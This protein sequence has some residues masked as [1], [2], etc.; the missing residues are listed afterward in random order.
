MAEVYFPLMLPAWGPLVMAWE[1]VFILLGPRLLEPLPSGCS[2]HF[3][4]KECGKA[5]TSS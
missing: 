2:C 3:S 4:R 5:Q 1:Q